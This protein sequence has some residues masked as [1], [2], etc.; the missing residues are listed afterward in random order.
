MPGTTP[1]SV[2]LRLLEQNDIV[3]QAI[4]SQRTEVL[5]AM[6]SVWPDVVRF[7]IAPLEGPSP[8]G[9]RRVTAESAREDQIRAL[10][11]HDPVLGAAIDALD[12]DLID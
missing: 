12:L 7:D 2:T 9:V 3:A 6:Q 10:R 4:E 11:R 8:T 1:R 5:A